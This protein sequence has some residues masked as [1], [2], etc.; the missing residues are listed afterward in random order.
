MGKNRKWTTMKPFQSVVRLW[1][2]VSG[3]NKNQNVEQTR[4]LISESGL[5]DA[6]WYLNRYPDVVESGLDPLDHYA[7]FGGFEGR[8][9]GP[10]F[11]GRWYEERY[12]DVT[13]SGLNPLAHFALHGAGRRTRKARGVPGVKVTPDDLDDAALIVSSSLF[14]ADWYVHEQTLDLA[15]LEAAIHY[16]KIG[17]NRGASPSPLFDGPAYLKAHSD[18]RK[19][20]ANPLLHYLKHGRDQGRQI[21]PCEPKDKGNAGIP[22][23][24]EIPGTARIK[25]SPRSG[26][27]WRGMKKLPPGFTYSRR[28]FDNLVR[29][30]ELAGSICHVG[31]LLNGRGQ[32]DAERLRSGFAAIGLT[33]FVGIDILPGPN[34]DV[35]AD[36][37]NPE[38]FD[39]H[40]ELDRAFDIV[41]C[42]ALFEHVE[43]PFAC[44]QTVRRLMKP[45]GHLY[46]AGPWVQGYHAYPDDYWR[47]SLSGIRVLFPDLEWLAKWYMG[48]VTGK[49][50]FTVDCDDPRNERKLFA[51]LTD[52]MP[53][54]ISDRAMTNLNIGA[55]GRAPMSVEHHHSAAG[56]QSFWRMPWRRR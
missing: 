48:T 40:P 10:E 23:F 9:S 5:F 14:D 29:D 36:L 12:P 37:T 30:F 34:V 35:V 16:L 49:G 32:A 25:P 8:W 11:H 56:D 21:V 33:P 53:V 44:A 50:R 3:P 27:N 26:G 55:L 41:Y 28:Y 47:I 52:Q 13:L 46:F 31:S 38:I 4:R 18:V 6:D 1:R 17:A 22:D 54:R 20:R 15:P 2:L 43:N 39:E 45:G 24:A 42:S 51:F 19:S 7:R